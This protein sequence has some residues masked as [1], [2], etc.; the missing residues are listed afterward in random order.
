ML[1]LK[2]LADKGFRVRN[3]ETLAE[4][5]L[6]LRLAKA[7]SLEEL[8]NLGTQW[9]LDAKEMLIAKKYLNPERGATCGKP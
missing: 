4:L 7:A 2:H 3:P 1:T 9:F 6:T 5:N 8:D